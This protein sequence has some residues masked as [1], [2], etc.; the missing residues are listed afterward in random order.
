MKYIHVNLKRFDIPRALGGVNDLTLHARQ[1]WAQMIIGQ[2]NETITQFDQTKYQFTFY[3]PEAY[4]LSAQAVKSSQSPIQI[5][6]QSVI[7]EDTLTSDNIGAY[8]TMRTASSMV[9]IGIHETII[10][11]SEERAQKMAFAQKCCRDRIKDTQ[12][13]QNELENEIQAAQQANMQVL[14]CVGESAIARDNNSWQ[15]VLKQQL[16]FDQKKVD[17]KQLKIAYE[18]LWAIGPNR[19][20]PDSGAIEEVAAY[21]HQL[22]GMDIPVL[23]G[24]GLKATNAQQI[25]ALPDVDGGL[26]ALTNFSEHI[27]FYPDQFIDIVKKYVNGVASCEKI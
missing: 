1:D 12:I 11:H 10:G 2:L 26:V 22:V 13:V 9:G 7:S 19:P 6:C 15:D 4:L 21:I 25:A 8:T 18:P 23:Y 24:G 17:L 16:T 14:Y 5:G 27:G 3:L 20:V